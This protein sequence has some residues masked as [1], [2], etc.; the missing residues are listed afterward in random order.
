MVA[1]EPE[2]F[3]VMLFTLKTVSVVS[4]TSSNAARA[5]AGTNNPHAVMTARVF[6]IRGERYDS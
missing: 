1:L 4:V 3:S 2:T 6:F 5:S